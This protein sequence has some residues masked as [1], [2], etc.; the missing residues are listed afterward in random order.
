M[1]QMIRQAMG[2]R[3]GRFVLLYTLVALASFWS[4]AKANMFDSGCTAS[5]AA[6]GWQGA[7]CHT[8]AGGPCSSCDGECQHEI[9]EGCGGPFNGAA[10]CT[11]QPCVATNCW[12]TC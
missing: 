4:G 9:C 8:H 11:H 3:I 12:E 1:K 7:G 6:K 5:M 2:A 10:G